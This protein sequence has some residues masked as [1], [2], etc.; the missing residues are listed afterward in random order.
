MSPACRS[1]AAAAAFTL[2]LA[3]CES[4]QSVTAP[5]PLQRS[6]AVVPS[7]D[8]PS[9]LDLGNWNIEWFGNTD[10]G[11]TDE[12][13]Q[14]QNVESVLSGANIDVWGLEEVCDTVQFRR[15][16]NGMP[17]YAAMVANDPYVTDGPAYYSDFSNT[18]Q[19]VAL[20]YRTSVVTLLSAKVILKQYD[21]DFAGRPPVEFHVRATLNG[22]SE[23]MVIIVVHMKS[24]S[25]RTAYSERQ[26]A[27]ADLKTYLDATYPNEKVWVIG[28][29]NDDVDTSI[30]RGHTSP[31]QNFVSDAAHYT[32]PTKELSEAKISTESGYSDAIDHQL[33]TNE[34]YAT[35]VAGSARVFRADSYISNYSNNTSDHYPVLVR[36]TVSGGATG[37]VPPTANFSSSCSS[38]AC[39]FTDASSDTDGTIASWSWNFGDGAT[40]TTRNPSHTYAAAGSYT[41]SL[42]VTDNA[43]ATG[44]TSKSVSVT[45]GGASG[46]ISI[47]EILANESGGNTS[48]EGIEL[49]NVG[50][51]SVDISGWT[52]SDA[53]Q[54]RHTFASG[55]SVAAGKAI[56]VFGGASSIPS[57]ITAVAASTGSLSLNNGGDTVTLKDASGNVVQAFTYSS[58]LSG[59]DGVSMNRNPD[60][61]ATGSFVLHTSISTLSQSIGKRAD[62]TA[63]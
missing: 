58:A 20:L 19:K 1:I 38:L 53:L 57:G 51:A 40:S 62:G 9:V 47:N 54:V 28:D 35:Y 21:A 37:N 41:V 12:A 36:Y 7:Q 5:N 24:G 15:V 25:D 60:G 30:F 26:A 42:T 45:S 11:P 63:W 59:Q 44:S 55:T 27:S 8:D 46:Q 22:S 32:F 14:E 43:G 18:E 33:N 34:S 10:F 4:N 56:S 52:L 29:F 50:T 61:S 3:A 2:L 49:L 31:Y 48:G 39:S 23:D 13:L 6:A 16:V 17:G